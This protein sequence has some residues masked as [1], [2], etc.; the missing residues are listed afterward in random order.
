[1]SSESNCILCWTNDNS[2]LKISWPKKMFELQ[3]TRILI[4]PW[5][6]FL[7]V[8]VDIKSMVKSLKLSVV[9]QRRSF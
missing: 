9:K 4:L 1:M 2:E 5:E 7:M 3:N 8:A 6:T